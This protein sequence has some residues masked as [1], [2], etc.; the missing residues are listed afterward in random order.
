LRSLAGYAE[1]L[2]VVD[3]IRHRVRILTYGCA[4]GPA[5]ERKPYLL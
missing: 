5:R 4:L 1:H 2:V 3:L